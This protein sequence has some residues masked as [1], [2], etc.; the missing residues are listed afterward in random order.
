MDMAG[1]LE[2]ELDL[3]RAT[4][5]GIGNCTLVHARTFGLNMSTWHL[6]DQHGGELNIA[7]VFPLLPAL[8][9]LS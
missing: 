6:F 4:S 5:A 7:A 9:T 8:I 2:R 3:E 1:A